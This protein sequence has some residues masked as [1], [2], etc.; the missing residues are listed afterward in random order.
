M[1]VYNHCNHLIVLMS[2]INNYPFKIM[3]NDLLSRIMHFKL[4]YG[5]AILPLLL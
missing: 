3:L 5:L 2:L 4:Y 1:I